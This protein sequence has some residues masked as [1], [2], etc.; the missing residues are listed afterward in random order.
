M[1]NDILGNF[2]SCRRLRFSLITGSLVSGRAFDVFG[3]GR[4]ACNQSASWR[5]TLNG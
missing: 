5:D 2:V 1:T 4:A 3:A